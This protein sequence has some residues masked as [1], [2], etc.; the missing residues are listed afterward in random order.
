MIVMMI[1]TAIMIV[2]LTV[3]VIVIALIERIAMVFS[4]RSG[5]EVRGYVCK[6]E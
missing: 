5:V 3:T 4:H 2:K 6:D 1:V